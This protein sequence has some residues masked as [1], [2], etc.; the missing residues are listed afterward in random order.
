MIILVDDR[1]S[2][3]WDDE[4]KLKKNLYNDQVAWEIYTFKNRCLEKIV[5]GEW[6]VEE[7]TEFEKYIKRMLVSRFTDFYDLA[8]PYLD[9][10]KEKCEAEIE[11]LSGL[12]FIKPN[13]KNNSFHQTMA[14]SIFEL[15]SRIMSLGTVPVTE[16]EKNL[17][18]EPEKKSKIYEDIIL[19]LRDED[20]DYVKV[21]KEVYKDFIDVA[22]KDPE[23]KE[24][25][26]D[27]D[28]KIVD[29]RIKFVRRALSRN[30]RF[31]Q[32]QK[33]REAFLYENE[34][35]C[36]LKKLNDNRTADKRR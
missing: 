28:Y 36:K 5:D 18:T 13:V 1:V 2:R 29:S 30:N 23:L 11:Y 27:L 22:V 25:I 3:F 6:T 9:L 34:K 26:M 19:E 10:S 35:Y 14:S 12:D 21:L 16:E 8:M 32:S 20:S 15:N 4:Q 31:I 33:N 7:Y 17:P 24:K